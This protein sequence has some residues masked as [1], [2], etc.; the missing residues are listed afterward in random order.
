M[1]HGSPV[2]LPGESHGQKSLVGYSPWGCKESEVTEVTEHAR[3]HTHTEKWCETKPGHAK[4]EGAHWA[5]MGPGEAPLGHT[6]AET[7]E[8]RTQASERPRRT[9]PSKTR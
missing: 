8:V 7:S 4:A 3:T 6:W 5:E 1:G 2:F 9:F